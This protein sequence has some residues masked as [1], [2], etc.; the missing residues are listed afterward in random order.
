MSSDKNK[1][2]CKIMCS[3]VPPDVHPKIYSTFVAFK[4]N[5]ILTIFHGFDILAKNMETS[6]EA[7]SA[8]INGIMLGI[9]LS[10]SYDDDAV[11]HIIFDRYL[12]EVD[13]SL[14]KN[15]IDFKQKKGEKNL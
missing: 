4:K 13:R 5:N 15:V 6:G 10:Q 14:G 8:H 1:A 12:E 2:L 7:A 9:M 3:F 11:K